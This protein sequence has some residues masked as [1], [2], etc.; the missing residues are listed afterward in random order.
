[1]I[2][3]STISVFIMWHYLARPATHTAGLYVLSMLLSFI[4]FLN[5]PIGDQL[6]HSVLD[7]SSP[8]LQDR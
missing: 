8:H 1:M 2:S 5:D 6:S 7:R 4:F 3:Y